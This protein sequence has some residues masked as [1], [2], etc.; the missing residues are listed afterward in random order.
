M[1]KISL[2]V[3]VI[4]IIASNLQAQTQL[5]KGKIMVGVSSTLAVGGAYDSNLMS[6]GFSKTKYKH[7]GTTEDAYSSFVF[8]ILPKGGYFIM[9]NLAAGLEVIITGYTDKDAGDGDKYTESTFGV[10][11]FVRYYYP[12]DKIYPFAEAE[13]LFGSCKEYYLADNEKSGM[14]MFGLSLG[15]AVP[16][17][18]MVTFDIMAGYLRSS[19]KYT[20]GGELGDE[21]YHDITGGVGLRIGLT[22]YLSK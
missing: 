19:Y 11:P 9:D 10:G 18:E 14:F 17:G 1:K 6:L 13:V 16:V 8:N 22:V 2:L 15:A 3:A 20:Y 5:E 4:C 21:V 12:L 7:D